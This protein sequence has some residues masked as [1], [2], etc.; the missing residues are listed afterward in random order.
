MR[1]SFCRVLGGV[2][3]PSRKPRKSLG[4]HAAPGCQSKVCKSCKTVFPGHGKEWA[5]R[6]LPIKCI[7]IHAK[8]CIVRMSL[9]KLKILQNHILQHISSNIS[10]T[11]EVVFKTEIDLRV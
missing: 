6:A 10:I 3:Q 7:R 11:F 4:S 1:I 9:K 8:Y 2:W 5:K